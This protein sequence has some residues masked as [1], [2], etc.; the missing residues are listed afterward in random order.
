M[1]S[2][3]EHKE[4]IE[5]ESIVTVCAWCHRARLL[6]RD[7]K[8]VWTKHYTVNRGQI[9]SH[10]ICPAC[11]EKMMASGTESLAFC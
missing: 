11:K 1:Q 9:I 3:L 7:F 8:L 5:A 10:T 4:S 2:V 6:T